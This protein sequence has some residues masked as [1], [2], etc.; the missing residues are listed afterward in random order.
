MILSCALKLYSKSGKLILA[1]LPVLVVAGILVGTLIVPKNTFYFRELVVNFYTD[2]TVNLSTDVTGLVRSL[3]IVSLLTLFLGLVMGAALG[4]MAA[5]F[6]LGPTR[7]EGDLK[8]Y[9]KSLA[10]S[11]FVKITTATNGT[12][13]ELTEVGKRFLRDYAFLNRK[14]ESGEAS[15][16]SNAA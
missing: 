11:G 6:P 15:Q 10:S 2:G 8:E 4:L 16:R 7:T 3:G 13:Y 1:G 5:G 12:T 9:E 14:I